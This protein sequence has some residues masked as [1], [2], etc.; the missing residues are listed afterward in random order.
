MNYFVITENDVSQWKDKTGELYHFPK[1]F[2][3]Y[4]TPGTKVVYYKGRLTEQV[5]KCKRLS[6]KPHYFGMAEIGKVK[7]DPD[8]EK[9]DYFADILNYIPFSV[10]VYA[11][12]ENG[13]YIE[14]IPD[15]KKLN[16][17]RDGAR[18]IDEKIYNLIV[19][20]SDIKKNGL[21]GLNDLSQG[22][23]S[24]FE[25]EILEGAKKQ[26]FSS[27]YERDPK[28]RQQALT[29]HG[30]SCAICEFNFEK[31]YG[32]IGKGFIHVHHIKPLASSGETKVNPR[33]DLI[34]VCPNCHSIIHRHKNSIIDHTELKK[35]FQ[36]QSK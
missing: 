23:S 10:P 18:Q 1:K 25:S 6:D 30:Y 16:Y 17:W 28:L 12:K 22:T 4:L 33:K 9:N 3:N 31:T 2:L 34:V 27:I 21:S 11:K 32:E 13:D 8:S 24:A 29:I 14:K 19:S 35:I 20:L 7:A 26:R 5:Y 36:K 15:S